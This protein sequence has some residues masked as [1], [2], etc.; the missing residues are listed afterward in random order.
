MVLKLSQIIKNKK[1]ALHPNLS[2]K[3]K[4]S[5]KHDN[6]STIKISNLISV[7]NQSNEQCIIQGTLAP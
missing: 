7:S 5:K 4:F 1:K 6:L 3:R 2:P